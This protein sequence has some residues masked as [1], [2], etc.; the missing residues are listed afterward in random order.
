MLLRGTRDGR[1]DRFT[2]RLRSE[3]AARTEQIR[4]VRAV[5][6]RALTNGG[7]TLASAPSGPG[8][9]GS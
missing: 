9:T 6:V 7:P 2:A 8:S 1:G 3:I 4:S 5:D